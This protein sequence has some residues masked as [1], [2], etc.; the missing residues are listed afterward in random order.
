MVNSSTGSLRMV[1]LHAFRMMY[2]TEKYSFLYS[3]DFVSG[4][5]WLWPT[6]NFF[7]IGKSQILTFSQ[8]IWWRLIPYFKAGLVSEVSFTTET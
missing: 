1:G 8:S 3:S 4:I 5:F 7:W 6:P 2:Y